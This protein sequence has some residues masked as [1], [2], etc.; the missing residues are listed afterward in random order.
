MRLKITIVRMG[1]GYIK[2][3]I[4]QGRDVLTGEPTVTSIFGHDEEELL[5]RLKT[6][7]PG[8]KQQL[9]KEHHELIR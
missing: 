4:G 6:K 5:N 8:I 7:L 1:G 3:I 2:A 9:K